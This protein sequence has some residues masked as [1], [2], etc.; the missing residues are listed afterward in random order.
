MKLTK[1]IT[2]HFKKSPN[3]RQ[4]FTA[5]T[6]VKLSRLILKQETHQEMRYPKVT[7]RFIYSPA[8]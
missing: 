5:M 3:S 2:A 1:K 8:I 6:E 7:F 4:A